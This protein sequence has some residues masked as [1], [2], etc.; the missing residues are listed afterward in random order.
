MYYERLTSVLKMCEFGEIRPCAS[1]INKIQ[2]DDCMLM[3]MN[4]FSIQVFKDILLVG[5]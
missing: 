1:L 3:S 5:L 4:S 2:S